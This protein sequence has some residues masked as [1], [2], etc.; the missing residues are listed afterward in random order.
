MEDLIAFIQANID[1]APWIIFGALL[2]AGFNI[3]VSE[4]GM[5]FI[6][7]VLAST[8]PGTRLPFFLGVYGGAYFSDLICYWLGRLI[9]P[10]LFKIR[11]FA[12]M[13]SP[14]KI[15]KV[16]YYFERYGILTL[17]FG[18]FI[19]FGFRNAMFLTA[20]FSKMNFIKFALADLVACTISVMT[21]FYLYYQYGEAVIESVK[22]ANIIIFAIAVSGLIGY[23]I[24]R[25]L[26]KKKQV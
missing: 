10:K 25:R 12:S 26:Q 2:L 19:P 14:E 5:I 21:Y 20:G 24:Y 4:D 9:G 3:P 15:E 11:F 16:S 8:H 22:D 7:A 23:L 1:Y 18:R 6:S 17:I 13:A